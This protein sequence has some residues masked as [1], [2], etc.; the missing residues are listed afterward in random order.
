MFSRLAHLRFTII[1]QARH[2]QIP[3][4]GHAIRKFVYQNIATRNVYKTYLY[5]ASSVEYEH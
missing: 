4:E 5:I 3:L 2:I 1:I